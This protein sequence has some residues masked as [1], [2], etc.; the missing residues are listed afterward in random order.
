[1]GIEGVQLGRFTHKCLDRGAARNQSMRHWTS[2]QPNKSPAFSTFTGRRKIRLNSGFWSCQCTL[3]NVI[4]S[5]PSRYPTLADNE[6][7]Q[8]DQ[9][10]GIRY[11][12]GA[13]NGDPTMAWGDCKDHS[14][15]ALE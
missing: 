6:D 15:L 5:L 11:Q 10:D 2:S 1:M 4:R 12:A 7:T 9:R 3:N 14:G 8:H 13:D